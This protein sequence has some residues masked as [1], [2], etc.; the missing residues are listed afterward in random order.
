MFTLCLLW[1]PFVLANPQWTLYHR[2]YHPLQDPVPFRERGS[3]FFSPSGPSFLPSA[4]LAHDLANFAEGLHSLDGAHLYQ[5]ALERK[6]EIKGVWDFSSVK[7][8]RSAPH[9]IL[10]QH[11]PHAA[12]FVVSPPDPC[13]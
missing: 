7:A 10:G 12:A 5:V 3:L 9:I 1:L 8:V 11:S 2:I 13:G 4:N 6:D